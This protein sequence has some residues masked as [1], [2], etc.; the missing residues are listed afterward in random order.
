MKSIIKSFILNKIYYFVREKYRY[1]RLFKAYKYDLNHYFKYSMGFTINKSKKKNIAEII[2]NTH[3]IEKGLTMPK[4]KLGFGY[5][6]LEKLIDIVTSYILKFDS[7]DPQV[8]HSISVI[9]EYFNFHKQ[10][11]YSVNTVLIVKHLKL[12][13][14]V[15]LKKI[16]YKSRNQ[17]SIDKSKYF[18][19]SESSFADFSNSRSSIRNFT[20][21]V[22]Q[23][24]IIYKVLDLARNTPS[25]CNRQAVRVHLYTK[26]EQIQKILTIQGGNRGFGHLTTTLLIITF[27]PSLYFEESERNSG[28]VDGGM[29]CMN[30]LYSLHA[31]KIAGCI[32]NAA[33]NPKKD[34]EIRK[35]TNL[36][37]SESF[38]AMIACGMT[39]SNFKV[40]M[41]YRYP[42]SYILKDHS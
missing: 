29:Y 13:E 33:H 19:F 32:L 40:A 12:L 3:V 28:Y 7:I 4:T 25:A 5:S 24:E 34:I 10:K 2:L 9:N 16:H 18:K 23:K 27:E 21:E 17:I 36:P 37:D 15:T 41:S 39:P 6:R 35:Y 20:D 38:V 26:K 30:L 31:N 11:G 22:V 8:L 1:L 42:L 14:I